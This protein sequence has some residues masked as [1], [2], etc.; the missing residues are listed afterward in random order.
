VAAAACF[1]N[2]TQD[3]EADFERLVAAPLLR[4]ISSAVSKNHDA[5]SSSISAP[6]A[7]D[8]GTAEKQKLLNQTLLYGGEYRPL[9]PLSECLDVN[10]IEQVQPLH[11][12]SDCSPQARK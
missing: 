9:G 7:D 6:A 8:S 2:S 12:A 11:R 5:A 10:E 3:S 4:T 1:F